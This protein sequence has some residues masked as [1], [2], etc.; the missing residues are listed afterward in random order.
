MYINVTKLRV[1]TIF[2]KEMNTVI[3]QVFNKLCD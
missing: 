1:N 3:E 2:F